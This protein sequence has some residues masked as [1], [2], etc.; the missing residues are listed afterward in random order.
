MGGVPDEV[1]T[2]LQ[3]LTNGAGVHGF[4]WADWP[5]NAD[6]MGCHRDIM[7]ELGDGT[8]GVDSH[9]SHTDSYATSFR[10]FYILAKCLYRYR[11]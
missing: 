11:Q 3:E 4:Q 2:V 1:K 5:K 10:F 9:V 6:S 7:G 8:L